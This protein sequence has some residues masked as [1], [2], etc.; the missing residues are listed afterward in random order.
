M[1]VVFVDRKAIIKLRPTA[2]VL[3]IE[4][5]NCSIELMNC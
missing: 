3:T 1:A 2:N 5:S 4:H